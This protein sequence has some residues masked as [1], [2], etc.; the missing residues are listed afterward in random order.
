MVFK[1]ILMVFEVL[2]MVFKVLLMVFKVLLMPAPWR[3]TSTGMPSTNS[4]RRRPAP[5][6]G[7]LPLLLPPEGTWRRRRRKGGGGGGC[8]ALGFRFRIYVQGLECSV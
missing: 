4:Q 2:L 5:D 6:S 1:V 7:S 3:R 8:P